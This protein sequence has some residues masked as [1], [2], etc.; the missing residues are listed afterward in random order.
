[1]DISPLLVI[2]VLLILAAEF[3]NGWTDAPNAIAT[4]VATRVMSPRLAVVWATVLNFLGTLAGTE[5][6]KTIGKG[7]VAPESVTLLAVC[8]AMMALVFW[9]TLAAR[10]GLP[11]SE[12]H[13]LIAGLT[14]AAFAQQG[15]S[16]LQWEGWK[17]VISGLGFSTFLGFLGGLFIMTA[18]YLLLR[19]VSR[20]RV[21]NTS[22]TLQ[23]FSSG[24]MA[25]SHG[26]ND[27]QKFIGVLALA[28]LLAGVHK[29]F[30]IPFWVQ[31]IAALTMGL[32]TAFGGWKIMKKMGKHMTNIQPAQGFAAEFAAASTIQLASH[33]GIPLSTTHT[34]NTSIMGVASAKRFS[35]VRWPIAFQI[36]RAWILTF[37]ICAALAY[38]L[39]K[40]AGILT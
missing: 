15:L 8:A 30:T 40:V 24:F 5:V 26:T 38:L 16:A 23:I 39:V 14:G 35:A 32:G 18:M 7:I 20:Q 1:M 11:T 21:T 13:A 28:L 33:F 17:K 37:P 19:K 36:I 34:I 2:T 25:F 27:G 9:S 6:A 31:I 4:V 12:S 22:K 29:E 10:F 3:V